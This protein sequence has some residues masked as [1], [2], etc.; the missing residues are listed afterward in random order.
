[1]NGDEQTFQVFD[2]LMIPEAENDVTLPFEKA[3]SSEVGLT[4][5]LPAV[6]FHYKAIFGT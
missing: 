2:Y 5:V 6:Q 3:R 4:P 1:M